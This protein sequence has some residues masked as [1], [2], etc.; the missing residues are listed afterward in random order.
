MGLTPG[1]V[2]NWTDGTLAAAIDEAFVDE[3]GKAKNVRLPSAG[4]DDRRLLFVAIARGILQF[5][6]DNEDALITRIRLQY[7]PSVPAA[8]FSVLQLELNIDLPE[9]S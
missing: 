7:D 5:L 4:Q 6:N 8:D 2:K 1:T 3:W 9:P